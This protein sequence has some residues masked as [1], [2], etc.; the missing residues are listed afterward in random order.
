MAI[1]C[2]PVL[3]VAEHTGHPH[4]PGMGCSSTSDCNYPGCN[5]RDGQLRFGC[6]TDAWGQARGGCYW[7]KAAWHNYCDPPPHPSCGAG[8]Y[9]TLATT[10]RNE[11]SCVPCPHDT[12]S[13]VSGWHTSCLPCPNGTFT[14]SSGSIACTLTEVGKLSLMESNLNAAHKDD[15]TSWCI[16]GFTWSPEDGQCINACTHAAVLSEMKRQDPALQSNPWTNF[17]KAAFYFKHSKTH[18]CRYLDGPSY[19]VMQFARVGPARPPAP[20]LGD[21]I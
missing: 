13:N 4:P 15:N 12:Y 18:G 17:K 20:G 14:A 19:F 10:A 9:S 21:V 8:S 11:S 7:G 2:R 3:I 5:D 6:R 16:L 1:I